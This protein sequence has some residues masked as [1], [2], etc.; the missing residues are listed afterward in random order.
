[1]YMPPKGLT[2]RITGHY[3]IKYLKCC[4]HRMPMEKI[5]APEI[6]A[7]AGPVYMV[8]EPPFTLILLSGI[9]NDFATA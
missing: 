6:P 2:E 5:P 1:M 4:R 3:V 7:T 8:E 9:F